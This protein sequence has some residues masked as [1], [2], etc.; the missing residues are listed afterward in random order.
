MG[1]NNL[2]ASIQ[3]VIQLGYLEHEF[4]KPL[5]AKLGFRAIADR[6]DFPAAIGE[7]ITKTRTGLLSAIT[8]ALAPA[9]N[10]DFTSGL[11]PQNYGVEQYI[12]A[13]NMFAANMQLNIATSK[14]AIDNLFLRNAY[15]L[16]EQ[17][18]RSVD[19]LAQSTIFN[20]YLG[21]NTRV[22][23]TLGAA[24]V[25]I[26]VDDVRGFQQT[27]NTEGQPVPVSS[28]FPVN[29]VVGS[30]VYALTG[31]SIDGTNVSTAPG[32]VSGTLTFSTS[33]TISDGTAGNAVV[34]S[35]APFVI[36]PSTT[37]SEIM[38]PTTAAISSANDINNG[39]ITMQMVLQA[40][41]TMSA[42]AVPPVDATGMYHLYV[43]PIQM[44]GLYQD[45]AFQQFFRGQMTTEEYRRGVVAELL[46]VRIEETNLNPVQ[47]L[48]GVGTVRRGLLCGQGALVE[49]IFTNKAYEDTLSEGGGEEGMIIVEDGIAHVTREPLDALKQ[50][51]TQTWSYIGGFTVPSDALTTSATVP[52]ANSSAFKR[53]IML[54][55]L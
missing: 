1:I 36:R 11:T 55:S 35:V 45:P 15:T 40:K 51:V 16:A 48:A 27:L 9:A 7:T 44:T 28:S 12:L 46:G 6:E 53:A 54:E 10:S 32:G 49:G 30:D 29:V 4:R 3:S 52:T 19:T 43:D 25:T 18:F 34:N 41:S 33:V 50:V 13:I 8:T 24:G 37:S 23:T 42:N 17:A 38:A 2:P 39:K 21:G 31:F 5:R 47:V 26:S 20:T 22:R 14:V